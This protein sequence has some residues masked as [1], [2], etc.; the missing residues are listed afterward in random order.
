MHSHLVKLLVLRSFTTDQG[1]TSVSGSISGD[2]GTFS[3]SF[4]APFDGIN[5]DL[6]KAYYAKIQLVFE[7][8]GETILLENT[9]GGS[10]I[11]WGD[12][13]GESH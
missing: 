6:V 13:K 11:K 3:G 4:S 5:N 9:T 7:C 10:S 1:G 2:V 12:P 8:N